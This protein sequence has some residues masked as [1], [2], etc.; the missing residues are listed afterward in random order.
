MRR[1]W[2]R[3]VLLLLAATWLVWYLG[4]FAPVKAWLV[5]LANEPDVR[6]A[7][8]DPE[9][10]RLDA[11]LMLLSFLMVAPMV[12]LVAILVVIFSL[13]VVAL[14]LE[15]LLAVLRLPGWTSVPIVLGTYGY[16]AF[17]LNALW[18]PYSVHVLG[19]VARAGIVYFTM[20]PAVPH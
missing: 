9:H 18:V 5:A 16:L 19:L 1:H 20:A 11:L 8:R 3:W 15:P 14:L 4:G 10:G 13:V 2:A 7:F 6:D 12:G 17:A